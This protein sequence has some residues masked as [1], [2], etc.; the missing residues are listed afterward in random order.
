MAIGQQL[1]KGT[2]DGVCLGQ[3]TSDKL[4]FF[5]LATPIV[6][7]AATNQ[8]AP[9]NTLAS[10]ISATQWGFTTSTQLHSLVNVV[11]QMRSDLVALGLIKGSA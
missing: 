3:S 5:G 7:P 9:S 11:I 10:T 2:P 6:Q 4:G 8:A 1:S